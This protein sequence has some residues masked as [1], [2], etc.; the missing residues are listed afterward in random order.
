MDVLRHPEYELYHRDADL[1]SVCRDAVS[2][3]K[4]DGKP[5]VA[6]DGVA[7]TP[8]RA[9]AFVEEVSALFKAYNLVLWQ[10][11]SYCRRCQ[12]GC[13]VVG[14]SQVATFDA[15]ALALLDEPFPELAPRAGEGD[16]IYLGA[17]GC[18]WPAAWRP[19]KCWSFYCLGSG[20]WEIDA[21]DARYARITEA[22]RA[23]VQEHLPG[24]LQKNEAPLHD[25][26]ADPIAFADALG[27]VLYA[28]FVAP[29][30]SRYGL[31]AEEPRTVAK[32]ALRQAKGSPA[33]HEA[34]AFITEAV[35]MLWQDPV[36]GETA[37]D[38]AFLADLESLEWILAQRPPHAKEA[39][40]VLSERYPGQSDG[41]SDDGA[42]ALRAQMGAILQKLLH[43]P[44]L[45]A[46]HSP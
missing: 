2:R 16:C 46:V 45:P 31:A 1:V 7:W 11:F 9:R 30:A 17:Q 19:I 10:T 44:A 41:L 29:F 4:E 27:E 32:F 12:G 38:E 23:T 43:D 5:L 40:G 34:R 22:L 36:S 33:I 14:A 26:L 18:R 24:Y 6:G 21:E 20:D 25:F 35:E 39:L 42:G 28:I 37:A 13:C 8:Q 3:W 15:L